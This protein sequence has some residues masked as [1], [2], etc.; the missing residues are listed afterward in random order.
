MVLKLG[1]LLLHTQAQNKLLQ[2]LIWLK[3]LKYGR[4]TS[5]NAVLPYPAGFDEA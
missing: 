5:K 2:F 3:Q 4:K 1:T